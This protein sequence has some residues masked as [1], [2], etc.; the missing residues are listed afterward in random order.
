MDT[1]I[2]GTAADPHKHAQLTSDRDTKHFSGGNT[3]YS[4]SSKCWSNWIATHRKKTNKKESQ[5]KPHS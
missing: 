2:Y 1:R 3:L 4:L 5:L